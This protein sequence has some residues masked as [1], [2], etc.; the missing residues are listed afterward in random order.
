MY[1]LS[2]L[3]QLL[4]EVLENSN[5]WNNENLH[6]FRASF[7]FRETDNDQAKKPHTLYVI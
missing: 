3:G 5:E 7:Y 4:F 1:L 2:T 6:P